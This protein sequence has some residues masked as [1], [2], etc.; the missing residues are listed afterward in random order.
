MFIIIHSILLTALV[1]LL[2]RV[3][4]NVLYQL[5]I[6]AEALQALLALV[7]LHLA[8]RA[9]LIGAAVALNIA[10]MLHLYCTLVHENLVVE[11][12]G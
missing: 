6:T 11:N 4:P 8:I 7:R 3:H 5:V 10:R 9:G 12:C 1:R 2:A